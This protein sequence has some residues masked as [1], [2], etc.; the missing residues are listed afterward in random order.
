MN[1]TGTDLCCYFLS[2]GKAIIDLDADSSHLRSRWR[3]SCHPFQAV[4]DTAHAAA[5]NT[6]SNVSILPDA[7]A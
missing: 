3:L 4:P 2:R 6:E 1:E 7:E 5:S